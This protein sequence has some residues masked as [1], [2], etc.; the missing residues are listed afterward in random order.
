MH[1]QCNKNSCRPSDLMDVTNRSGGC[2]CHTNSIYST[3]DHTHASQLSVRQP[4]TYT[5]DNFR[6]Y[7]LL[8]KE[9]EQVVGDESID[10][11]E[12]SVGYDQRG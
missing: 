9:G 12:N 2:F 10:W 3:I 6:K 11:S 5:I 7:R 8:Q 4:M 1:H